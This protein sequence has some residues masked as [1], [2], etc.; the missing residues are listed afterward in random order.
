MT[1]DAIDAAPPRRGHVLLLVLLPAVLQ[2]AIV[3]AFGSRMFLWDD[4]VYVRVFRE[5]G[6][7]KPW[8][9]WIWHQHNEHR[10]VWT[11]LVYF[12]HASFSGWNP[13]VDMYVSAL[14]TALI[15]WGIWNLYRAAGPG[16]LAYF[17]PVALL[18]CTLAQYMNILYGLMTCHYFTMAGMVWALVFLLRRTWPS[19]GIAIACAFGAIVSTLN[20]IVI[21]PIG[22]LVLVMTR[23]KPSRW[24]VW[25]AAMLGCGYAYFRHYQRPGHIPAIDWSAATILKAAD[26]FIVNLG[27]PLSAADIVW[28]RALGVM[29]MGA[30]LLLWL[31]VWIFD[32]RESHAGLVG[33]SLVPVG[34]AAAIALGRASVGASNALDSKYV[35]Y[36]TLALVTPYLGLACLPAL[37]ARREILAGLTAV[38]AVGWTAANLAGFEQA[39]AW[40]RDRQRGAYVLQTI[41]MQPDETVASI[42]GAAFV[43]QVRE[44]AGYLRATRLGP[45]HAPI[46]VLM[47]PRW[48]E[49]Q[50]TNAVTASSPLRV[51]IV[52]PVDTL[53]DVGLIVAPPPGGAGTGS[54]QVSVNAGGHVVGRG[55]IDAKDVQTIRYIRVDL[56]SPLRGC[57]GADLIIDA[58]SDSSGPA[59][60]VHSW[61]YPIYYAGVTRQ[62][63]RLIDQRSLGV[64]FNA[65]SYG[66]I[67]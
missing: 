34:C 10:I 13:F 33:L 15:A 50:P 66:L 20:A 39:Q 41:E 29:T 51:H 42:G 7:G 64:T 14:L 45:F 2:A 17:I 48:R 62:G 47:A 36:S 59:G 44:A 63:G 46:D 55:R 28:A 22:L 8:L 43:P 11:K 24:I 5:I 21:A 40:H 16:R 57:R 30:L 6:E 12:A 26:A 1:D 31:G 18:L 54:V 37:R 60:A 49:G 9:H 23:Q 67:D 27:S 61:T 65:F 35:I 32:R 52:C 3:A 38:I 4:F 19:L 53:V 58:M 56:D 25:S